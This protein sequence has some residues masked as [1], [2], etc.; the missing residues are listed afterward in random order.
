MADSETS[1]TLHAISRRKKCPAN[2]TPENLPYQI[3]RRNLLPV[4]AEL[5]SA[6]LAESGAARRESGP[7]PVRELWP[8]WYAR[9]RH[10]VRATRLRKR[11]AAEMLKEAGGTPV[12]DIERRTQVEAETP[13]QTRA[14]FRERR[15]L[16][17]QADQRLGYSAAAALEQELAEQAGVL[18]RVMLIMRPSSFIEVTAKLHCL[19]VTHDPGLKLEDP[20]WPEL[21]TML[22]DLIRIAGARSAKASARLM[23]ARTKPSGTFTST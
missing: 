13:A 9:Q 10:C 5:L 16:W 22:K 7:T 2:H 11:L 3:D 15:K 17:R 23:E 14:E 21:R 18:A 19:I 20:P 6:R 8:Q 1:R 12:A 4:A